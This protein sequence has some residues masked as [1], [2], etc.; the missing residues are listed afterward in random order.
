MTPKPE[1]TSWRVGRA[2]DLVIASTTTTTV[3]PRNGYWDGRTTGQRTRAMPRHELT[4]FNVGQIVNLKDYGAQAI[5]EM[6][7]SL[8]LSPVDSEALKPDVG[9][10]SW[11]LIADFLYAAPGAPMPI[12]LP[13]DQIVRLKH[14]GSAGIARMR[15]CGAHLEPLTKTNEDEDDPDPQEAA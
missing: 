1:P 9:V 2:A 5:E 10:A 15:E 8:A 14:F 11:R 3:E 7:W 13:R 12:T 6:R 4:R